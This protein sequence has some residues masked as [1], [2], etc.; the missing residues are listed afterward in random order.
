M[1]NIFFRAGM[2]GSTVLAFAV[3]AQSQ[4]QNQ[5]CSLGPGSI[6]LGNY[7]ASPASPDESALQPTP[8]TSSM[9][10]TSSTPASVVTDAG[11][12]AQLPPGVLA[13]GRA[14]SPSIPPAPQIS[15]APPEPPKLQLPSIATSASTK[16]MVKPVSASGTVF[17]I[18][19]GQ[20]LSTALEAWLALQGVSLVWDV[21]AG[22]E[23]VRD[24]EMIAPWQSSTP[25]IEKT[26]AQLLPGFGLRAIVQDSPRTVI[27]RA[28]SGTTGA[29]VTSGTSGKTNGASK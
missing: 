7:C 21:S 5:T 10:S 9:P 20:R 26:L 14:C 29:S 18:G 25:E 2:L 27:V 12:C 8:P 19:K 6:G 24:I 22:G 11:S 13:I 1:K 16:P 15:K 17:L 23:R 3:Q 4:T 28:A